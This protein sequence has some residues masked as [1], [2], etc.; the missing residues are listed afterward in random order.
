MSFVPWRVMLAFHYHWKCP[1][2]IKIEASHL[3]RVAGPASFHVQAAVTESFSAALLHTSSALHFEVDP[4]YEPSPT[5]QRQTSPF[6]SSTDT[7]R[8]TLMQ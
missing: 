1:Q 6:P 3:I 2:I 5:G 8:Y 7:G 4:T